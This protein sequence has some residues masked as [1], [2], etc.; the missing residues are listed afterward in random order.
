MFFLLK[1]WCY[2]L[3]TKGTHA[4]FEADFLI[5]VCVRRDFPWKTLSVL[6]LFNL[7]RDH[8]LI[9]LCKVKTCKLACTQA[10]YPHPCPPNCYSKAKQAKH[11]SENS[12]YWSPP[13]HIQTEHLVMEFLV[14][15]Q[16]YCGYTY[17]RIK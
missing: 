15:F 16:R 3:V 10:F 17:Y 11:S 9:Q 6:V 13:P 7:S 1:G 8:L 14:T 5:V 4:N 12:S 2:Y